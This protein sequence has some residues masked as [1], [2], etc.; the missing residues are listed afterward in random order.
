MHEEII[1]FP[2]IE[3]ETAFRI[4]MCGRSFCDGT[5][6]IT[7]NLSHLH[8]MEYI[9]KGEGTVYVDDVC[10]QAS[11]GDIYILPAGK[12]HY[13]YSDEKNPWEKIWFNISGEFVANTLSAYGL[14]NVYHIKNLDLHQDFERFLSCAEQIK[15]EDSVG[16]DYSKNAV[17]FLEIIQKIAKAPELTEQCHVPSRAAVL[18][19]K[20]DHLT[21]FTLT[22]DDIL[23]EFFYT[24]S[25]L[26]RTFK[27]EY[28]MTPYNYLLE[29]KLNTSK[30]L[31]R[32]TAMSITEISNYLGFSNCH[33]FSNFFSKRVGTSPKEYRMSL[34]TQ[35]KME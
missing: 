18:K 8:C 34:V 23:E 32:N 30:S 10:F 3:Q 5:Y 9:Y 13:Y 31:L 19:N 12:N 24:K 11:A 25:H 26:I 20:I 35:H 4:H 16:I 6:R 22:F 27:K 29:H 2:K 7:R 33:Y 21:D 14:E 15:Q 1:V 28:G 17:V